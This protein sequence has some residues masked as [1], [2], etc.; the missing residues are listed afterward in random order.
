MNF[1]FSY[2]KLLGNKTTVKLYFYIYQIIHKKKKKKLDI[3]ILYFQLSCNEK[4]NCVY[5]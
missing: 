3:L 2:K 4:T 1:F 5:R